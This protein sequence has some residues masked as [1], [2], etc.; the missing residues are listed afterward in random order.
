[1]ASVDDA[2]ELQDRSERLDE[3]VRALIE[4]FGDRALDVCERQARSGDARATAETWREL[5][6]RIRAARG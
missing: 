1:M 6:D 2:Q 4:Q 5:A 3:M